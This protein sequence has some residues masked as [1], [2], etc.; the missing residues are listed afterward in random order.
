MFSIEN[1]LYDLA[2]YIQYISFGLL[3]LAGFNV[4]ISED[5]V[6]IVSASVAAS[7]VPQ[8]TVYIFTGCFLGAYTSDIVAYSIGRFAGRKILEKKF[9]QKP[10]NI[11]RIKKIE[12]YFIR[13]GFK[14]L[15]FGRFIPLGMRNVIFITAGIARMKF[16]RFLLFDILALSIGISILFRIGF[17]FGKNYRVILPYLDQ[18]KYG[19][20]A[21]FFCIVT[22]I[23][24]KIKRTGSSPETKA[25]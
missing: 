10:V 12:Q 5:I 13:Y 11:E 16:K 14:T 6:F 20:F 21:L 9:F 18:F 17:V 15:F 22:F 24:I 8:N 4:P 19:I 23:I 2:P 7:V 3:V 25:K 1:L